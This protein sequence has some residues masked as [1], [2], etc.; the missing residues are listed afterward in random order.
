MGY[1]QIKSKFLHIIPARLPRDLNPKATSYD[2]HPKAYFDRFFILFGSVV[3]V[4]LSSAI[5]LAE[6]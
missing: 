3:L 2:R 1:C 6:S 4:H 5:L